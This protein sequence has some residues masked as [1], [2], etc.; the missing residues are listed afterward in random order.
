MAAYEDMLN[1]TAPSGPLECDPCDY[2]WFRP[3][4][5]LGDPSFASSRPWP[6]PFRWLSKGAP[7]GTGRDRA[8]PGERGIGRRH[9]ASNPGHRR[10]IPTTRRLIIMAYLAGISPSGCGPANASAPASARG[11]GRRTCSG[12][13]H[14]PDRSP[15]QGLPRLVPGVLAPTR[16][17]PWGTS[18]PVRDARNQAEFSPPRW[19]PVPAHAPRLSGDEEAYYGYLGAG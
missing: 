14:G 13:A 9:A 8:A 17:S 18:G 15:D 16:S 2:K 7:Q 12:R 4:G 11:W 5:G 1:H 3:T 10:R 6:P 19:R